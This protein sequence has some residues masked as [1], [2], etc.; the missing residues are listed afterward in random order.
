MCKLEE[1]FRAFC[2]NFA[3][4]WLWIVLWHKITVPGSGACGCCYQQSG[5]FLLWDT[6]FDISKAITNMILAQHHIFYGKTQKSAGQRGSRHA[7]ANWLRTLSA[8]I[9]QPSLLTLL[10]SGSEELAADISGAPVTKEDV[11]RVM[12]LYSQHFVI[13]TFP[14]YPLCPQ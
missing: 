12:S 4:C 10:C 14:A 5:A 3:N 2:A 13:F 11:V 9:I 8:P 6:P 1:K 7:P